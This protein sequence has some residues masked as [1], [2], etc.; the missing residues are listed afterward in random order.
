MAINNDLSAHNVIIAAGLLWT[1]ISLAA[2]GTN[3]NLTNSDSPNFEESSAQQYD[4]N[5]SKLNSSKSSSRMS[6]YIIFFTLVALSVL[7]IT[8]IMLNLFPSVI[9]IW[10]QDHQLTFSASSDNTVGTQEKSM[11]DDSLKIGALLPAKWSKSFI[12]KIH[13]NCTG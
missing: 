12:R 4:I 10:S 7:S 9:S 13:R 6:S 2:A 1:V 8:L 5:N 3:P 11:A